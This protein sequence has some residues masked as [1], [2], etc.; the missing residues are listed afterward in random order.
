M[1]LGQ[2]CPTRPVGDFR[3]PLTQGRD[4]LGG[5]Q[6]GKRGGCRVPH[7]EDTLCWPW[8]GWLV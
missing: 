4:R 7:V 3:I 2:K 1:T 5:D 6:A 8:L